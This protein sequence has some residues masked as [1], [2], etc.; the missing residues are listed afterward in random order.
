MN[1]FDVEM[2]ILLL[3]HHHEETRTEM[4]LKYLI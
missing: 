1:I 2:I 3:S 4:E